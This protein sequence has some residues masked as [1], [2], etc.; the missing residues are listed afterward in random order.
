MKKWDVFYDSNSW[1]CTVNPICL[2]FK[3]SLWL[4]G[5]FVIPAIIEA[6]NVYD[7]VNEIWKKGRYHKMFIQFTQ[8]KRTLLAAH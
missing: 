4:C 3:K 1:K 2:A 6:Q 8:G 5:I 7:F